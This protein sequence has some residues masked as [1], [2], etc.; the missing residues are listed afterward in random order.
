LSDR[1]VATV[2]E[3]REASSRVA[4][5]Q[6]LGDVEV[7]WRAREGDRVVMV[8][9]EGGTGARGCRGCAMQDYSGA[10]ALG[11]RQGDDGLRGRGCLFEGNSGR[12]SFE[13]ILYLREEFEALEVLS[14]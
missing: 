11:G 6:K 5:V 8:I 9:F 1:P 13:D 7:T 3:V 10:R 2:F 14:P 12:G 4:V